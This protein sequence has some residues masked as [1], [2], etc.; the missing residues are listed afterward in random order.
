M[1]V[2]GID[3]YM[4]V[5]SCRFR[6][7]HRRAGEDLMH[8]NC[9][10]CGIGTFKLRTNIPERDILYANFKNEVCINLVEIKDPS[11]HMSIFAWLYLV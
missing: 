8:D 2:N 11:V 10:M 7:L 4:F 3:M 1:M 5:Y 9:C 6:C